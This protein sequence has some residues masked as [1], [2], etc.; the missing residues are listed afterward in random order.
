MSK[1]IWNDVTAIKKKKKM[2]RQF[3][4]LDSVIGSFVFIVIMALHVQKSDLPNYLVQT[5]KF[6]QDTNVQFTTSCNQIFQFLVAISQDCKEKIFETKNNLLEISMITWE[7][8]NC[9]ILKSFESSSLYYDLTASTIWTN[10]LIIIYAFSC[11]AIVLILFKFK[12]SVLNL[13]E[14]NCAFCKLA[15]MLALRVQKYLNFCTTTSIKIV[16][17]EILSSRVFWCLV[18]FCSHMLLKH[19]EVLGVKEIIIS[20][21]SQ[22]DTKRE[23]F[24]DQIVKPEVIDENPSFHTF[25]SF[26]YSWII[27]TAFTLQDFICF[28]CYLLKNIFV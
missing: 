11:V 4:K 15:L 25:W 20:F 8:T 6:W 3:S 21:A 7:R 23:T 13:C 18:G 28:S 9:W 27:K 24:N 26:D 16:K 12:K 17:D 10:K 22:Y 1:N 2:G 14:L 5:K 19:Y